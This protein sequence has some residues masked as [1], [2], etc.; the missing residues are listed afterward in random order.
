MSARMRRLSAPARGAAWWA[1]TCLVCVVCRSAATEIHSMDE[2]AAWHNSTF[3]LA[4]SHG[5]VVRGDVLLMCD[6]VLNDT[7]AVMVPLGGKTSSPYSGVFDCGGHT[8]HNLTVSGSV[9]AGLFYQLGGA[10][11]KNFVLD[12]S[13]SFAR[14]SNAGAVCVRALMVK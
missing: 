5:Q 1:V 6:L 4:S 2:F 9:F 8:I 13:C 14:G 11:V 12:K 3:G 7:T 10:T